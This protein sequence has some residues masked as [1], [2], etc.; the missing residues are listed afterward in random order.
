MFGH[1]LLSRF[2]VIAELLPYCYILVAFAADICQVCLSQL[3][4]FLNT[5]NL[6]SEWKFQCYNVSVWGKIGTQNM[7]KVDEWL[8]PSGLLVSKPLVFVVAKNLML[9]MYFP[10]FSQV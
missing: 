9:A 4:G 5:L 3:K 2:L 8:H 1:S 7:G 10:K 6:R